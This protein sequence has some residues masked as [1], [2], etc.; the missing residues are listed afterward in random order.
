MELLNILLYFVQ[1]IKMNRKQIVTVITVKI[2]IGLI[3][4]KLFEKTNLVHQY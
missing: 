2:Y 1:S 3:N 4:V